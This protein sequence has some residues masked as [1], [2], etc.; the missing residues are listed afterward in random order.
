MDFWGYALKALD[1]LRHD[2]MSDEE[3]F[4]EDIVVEGVPT[5]RKVRKVK[6]LW[7]RH[8]LFSDLFKKIDEAR[9]VEELIF[10]QAGRTRIPRK[11]VQTIVNRE[12]PKGLPKSVFRPEYLDALS[13]YEIEE[14]ELAKEEDF[15]VRE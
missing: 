5:Q 14:L 15:A 3:D 7:F 1:I 10:T 11:R 9:E 4:S 6:V 13:K 8:E 12:P 2:G